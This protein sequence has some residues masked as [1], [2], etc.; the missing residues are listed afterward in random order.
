M[1][2]SAL[3]DYYQQ[4]LQNHPDEVSHPGWS[5]CKVSGYLVIG[6]E[7]DVVSVI[8]TSDKHGSVIPVP[9]HETR[10]V[11]IKPFFLCDTSSYLLGYDN[12]NK[13]KRT[14]DAYTASQQLHLQVLDGVDSPVAK[15]ISRFFASWDPQTASSNPILR[16][17]GNEETLFAGFLVLEVSIDGKLFSSLEDSEVQDAWAKYY[18]RPAEDDAVMRCLVTGESAPIARLHPVIK[19]VK[20]AQSSGAQLVSFN[21]RSG[22]SYGHEKEQGLN[23]PV[24]KKAVQG[25]GAALNYLLASPIH[26]AFLG[27]TTLTYWTR[28]N[29]D[30]N[31][32]FLSHFIFQQGFGDDGSSYGDQQKRLDK[33][34]KSA[35]AGRCQ[36]EYSLK[37]D[38]PFYIVGLAPNAARISVKFFLTGTF[39]SLIENVAEHYRRIDVAHAPTAREYLSPYALLHA[40]ENPHAKQPVYESPLCAPLLRSIFTNSRYPEGLF[41][42]AIVRIRATS[43]DDSKTTDDKGK[44]S[45][46]I[47]KVSRERAAILRAYLLKNAGLNREE[48]TVELNEDSKCIAY[49]LGRL[50]AVLETLQYKANGSTNLANRYMDSASTTPAMVFPVLLRLANAHL[51]KIGHDKS[52]LEH[53]YKTQIAALLGTGQMSQFPKRLNLTEQGEFFLGY[54]QQYASS[55]NNKSAK[56][57]DQEEQ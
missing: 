41:D 3:N 15:A 24:S 14:F 20:G 5:S 54:Y 31:S 47:R 35:V 55:F 9:E 10:T 18:F 57:T 2:L 50:F 6:P 13:P 53:W 16:Q 38:T 19:G 56:T 48:I 42:A 11:G 46:P 29:D 39:G 1:L 7:G 34:V 17:Q 49:N 33:V 21:T 4:L 27:D 25:Y 40:V 52:G 26:H 43:Q 36:D 45:G 51:N 12:K 23:A 37:F 8:P 44:S 30:T 22:E 28:E 32:D